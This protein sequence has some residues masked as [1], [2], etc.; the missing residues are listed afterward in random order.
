[1]FE[2]SVKVPRHYK[3]AANILKKVCFEGGSIKTLLYDNK[4][5]HFNVRSLYALV[6]TAVR[7]TRALT[8][9]FSEIQLLEK[10][11][12]LDP[13]LAR[14]LTIEILLGKKSLPGHSKPEQTLLAYKEQIEH[15]PIK[16]P[17]LFDF[18]GP[19]RP[20][21]V[22]VNT[23]KLCIEE[24][25]SWF[26]YEGYEFVPCTIGTYNDYL[27]QVRNL[28]ESQF[29]QDYHI[30]SIFVFHTDTKFYDHELYTNG[31]IFLQDKAS[32][33]AVHLLAPEMGSTVLDMCAAPGM[34][35]TQVAAHINNNGK[36]YACERDPERQNTLQ[37]IIKLAG[38][39]AELIA[40]D[41]FDIKKGML[42]DVEYILL[43]PSCSG[44]GM[45]LYDYKQA[46]AEKLQKLTDLQEKLLRHATTNF[47]RVKRIV[48][49]TCS[50]LPEE[51]EKVVSNIMKAAKGKWQI[52]SVRELL[53]NQWN[54]FGS[55]EAHSIAARC[56]Y[57]KPESDLT[58]GFFLAV[59]DRNPRDWSKCI[60]M[61]SEKEKVETKKIMEITR[62]EKIAKRGKL[63]ANNKQ[64]EEVAK[65]DFQ[66]E[67]ETE[68]QNEGGEPVPT[69]NSED[70]G[71]SKNVVAIDKKCRKQK[72][73]TD[74]ESQSLNNITDNLSGLL[75]E[76]EEIPKKKRKI[77]KLKQIEESEPNAS[78]AE[79]ISSNNIT[80]GEEIPKKRRKIGKLKQIEESEPNASRGEDISSNNITCGEEIPKKRRKIDKL[81]QIEKSEPNAS[82][83]EDISSNNITCGE[84]IPKKRR[85][86]D[87]LKQIEE[88]EPNASQGED[89]L[90]NN[91]ICGEEVPKK[92][93]R[94][95]HVDINEGA[96]ATQIRSDSEF[97]KKKSKK[98][99]ID[100]SE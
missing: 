1:M 9:L 81:K 8:R 55:G 34:K 6:T 46:G 69:V 28:T 95:R 44:S 18:K 56:L 99:N 98:M 71:H 29:L 23:L 3:A 59:M 31:R 14:I 62:Q 15:F 48:Y 49:S 47:P 4:L 24:F 50:L 74:G 21:Y 68:A 78:H 39:H 58:K 88:S 41:I 33:L 75:M 82:H 94:K 77:D 36:I 7:N 67:E 38:A 87:K 27:S 43:D 72:R 53:N 66:E 83:G 35:T 70:E 12:R 5:R 17:E 65:P 79:D 63:K 51:N 100:G 22:R 90:S 76:G 64:I 57:A 89:I 54:N 11:P 40:K 42:D 84:E 25:I 93:K 37:N 60:S 13:W 45:D 20:R 85:K 73:R 10:E 16:H 32:A 80:C 86:I 92:K 91:I 26:E 19:R 61:S 52:Q 2:H 30:K 96:E 97:T